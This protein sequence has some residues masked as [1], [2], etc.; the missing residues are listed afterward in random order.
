[1]ASM[2]MPEI[3]TGTQLADMSAENA[4][5]GLDMGTDTNVVTQVRSSTTQ[6]SGNT[7]NTVIQGHRPSRTSDFLHFGFGSF[8]R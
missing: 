2:E 7:S 5:A 8:A 6:N 4:L 1:M 3:D